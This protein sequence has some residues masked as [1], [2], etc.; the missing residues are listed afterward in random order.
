[1]KI[2]KKDILMYSNFGK[3]S[4]DILGIKHVKTY[5]IINRHLYNENQE[6]ILDN[7]YDS[8]SRFDLDTYS[9][10]I[11]LD[12]IK[13]YSIAFSN[14]LYTTRRAYQYC[15]V[16][17]INVKEDILIDPDIVAQWTINFAKYITEDHKGYMSQP[18]E[19]DTNAYVYYLMKIIFDIQPKYPKE[20][21]KRMIKH[22]DIIKLT[23]K[24]KRVIKTMKKWKII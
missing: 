6:M 2:D 4:C 3:A 5:F 12:K 1:M 20:Y 10:I 19:L 24:P 15:R 16:F 9:I 14:I 22:S 13:Q 21:N 18:L 11:N 17:K 8:E 7:I 23:I